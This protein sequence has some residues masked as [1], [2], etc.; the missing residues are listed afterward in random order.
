VHN[1]GRSDVASLTVDTYYDQLTNS[2]RIKCLNT[3][4][5][6]I[7]GVSRGVGLLLESES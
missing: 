7:R 5:I 3:S 4:F 2:K 6:S 1:G